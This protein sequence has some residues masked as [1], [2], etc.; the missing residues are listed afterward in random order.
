MSVYMP[1]MI[2]VQKMPEMKMPASEDTELQ[3]YCQIL[4]EAHNIGVMT[5]LAGQHLWDF[6]PSFPLAELGNSFHRNK[7]ILLKRHNTALLCPVVPVNRCWGNEATSPGYGRGVSRLL[8]VIPL[9]WGHH[10]LCGKLT[11]GAKMFV[12]LLPALP[13]T[14]GS[15]GPGTLS[16]CWAD[17]P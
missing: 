8:L 6:S 16:H 2:P 4:R 5:R 13:D 1:G 15:L 9:C 7:I 14:A 10:L 17:P 12:V 11:G 3:S